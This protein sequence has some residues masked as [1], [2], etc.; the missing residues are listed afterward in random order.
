MIFSKLLVFVFQDN[1]KLYWGHIYWGRFTKVP[2]NKSIFSPEKFATL[3]SWA[4]RLSVTWISAT[5]ITTWTTSGIH[6]IL[7]FNGSYFHQSKMKSCWRNTN[8]CTSNHHWL[9][10]T[11]S[12]FT[13]ALLHHAGHFWLQTL[14]I[15]LLYS[16]RKQPTSRE[17]LKWRPREMSAV[18]LGYCFCC[19]KSLYFVQQKSKANFTAG[20]LYIF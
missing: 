5:W 12:L 19:W 20:K 10:D 7:L 14:N 15:L 17:G 3:T 13:K 4:Y 2:L 16:L 6:S 9:R 11:T 18:F 8:T 1:Q